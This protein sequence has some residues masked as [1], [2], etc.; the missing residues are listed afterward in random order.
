MVYGLDTI[1][2]IDWYD[3]GSKELVRIQNRDGSWPFDVRSLSPENATAF[4]LLFLCRAN[5]AKDFTSQLKAKV[6]DPGSSRLKSPS[7]VA[8]GPKD[9][10]R[11]GPGTKTE[12]GPGRAKLETPPVPGAATAGPVSPQAKALAD[13]LV[14]ATGSERG[15]LL[16]RFRDARGAEYS[17]AL[18]NAIS[19]LS[20]EAKSQTRDALVHRLTRMTAATLISYMR[21]DPDP[22]LRR[23]AA[24]AAGAKGKERVA[25]FADTLIQLTADHNG[26]V[27][28]AAR[29]SLKALT[30]QDFGP[31][32]T[33]GPEAR[34]DASAKWKD[35][36]TKN[37]PAAKP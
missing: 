13:A 9:P 6:K 19:R 20:G 21:D 15:D 2:D 1:G 34:A 32:A 14:A 23:A 28:Q 5:L 7:R 25:E 18:L 8:E 26:T 31:D 22:E 35:W 37:K 36:W 24:L 17:E 10:G 11:I 3:W 16:A 29:A 27:A 12:P 4:A 33:A 30:G